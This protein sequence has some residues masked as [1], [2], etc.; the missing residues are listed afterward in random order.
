MS[1]LT[2][3]F[4]LPQEQTEAAIALESLAWYS[5]AKE[6]YQ[7]VETLP[8]TLELS[9]GTL[10]VLRMLR[11]DFQSKLQAYGLEFHDVSE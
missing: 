9:P 1:R 3:A 11:E 4:Q 8:T 7:V 2:L 6:F 10:E 5:V